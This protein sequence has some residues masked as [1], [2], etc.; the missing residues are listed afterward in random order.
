MLAYG[1]N[2]N[3]KKLRDR[4]KSAKPLRKKTK[5]QDQLIVQQ[6]YV[7]HGGHNGQHLYAQYQQDYDQE[8]DQEERE[9]DN[10]EHHDMDDQEEIDDQIQMEGEHEED[11]EYDHHH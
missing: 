2:K 7:P 4:P 9:D 10:Q 8:D 11:D 3:L 6:H 5:K 1:M